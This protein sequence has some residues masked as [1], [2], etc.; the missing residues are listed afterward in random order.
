MARPIWSGA[1]NFGLVTIPV[2]LYSAT[3]DHTISF[4]QFERGTSDRIRYKRINER[5]GKE[6]AF[7]D[8][9]KGADVGGG[10]F[11]IIEPEELD[12]IAPGRSRTIDI[13]TFVDLEDIDPIHFQKTYWL[14]PAKEEYGKSYSLLLQAME[15]TNRAGIASFVMRGKEYLTAVRAG[16]GLLVLNTLLF[17]AD[18]RDPAK[19]LKSLP[20][21]TSA[22]GKELDMAMNLIESMSDEWRPDEY[23]DTYTEQVEKLIETKREGKE[24]VAQEEPSEPTKVVDLFEALSRSVEGRKKGRSASSS[25]SSASS[26]DLDDLS[27]A[28]LEKL[29]KELDIKGRSKMNRDELAKAVA[30]A[31]STAAAS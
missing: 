6:V 19:E 14:A 3:E 21:I 31:Q 16:D 29:A 26:S 13:N 25:S 28:D 23:N 22:R 20:Q 18:I 5:T 8:I 10:E 27:K 11:V 4:R 12:Q 17:P 7:S 24:I 30:D 2:E 15:K 1:I 9:V